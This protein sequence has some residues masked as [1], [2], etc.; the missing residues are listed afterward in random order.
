[1]TISSKSLVA[2]IDVSKYD[3]ELLY[4][5]VRTY[6]DVSYTT[7]CVF[8]HI[9][10]LLK[11]QTNNKKVVTNRITIDEFVKALSTPIFQ[12][13]FVV[14]IL[15]EDYD[16]ILKVY[17][18]FAD[19]VNATPIKFNYMDHLNLQKLSMHHFGKQLDI[20]DSVQLNIPISC[21]MNK[22]VDSKLYC[23]NG[24]GSIDYF[25]N[26]ILELAKN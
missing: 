4:D 22:L 8:T 15:V 13:S 21:I 18:N 25:K 7:I 6:T 12:K 5:D 26:G 23:D 14:V 11:E 20:S 1:M 3:L 10:E 9:E 19:M 24:E 17:P 2:Y 16:E